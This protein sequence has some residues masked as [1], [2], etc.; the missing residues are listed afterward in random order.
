[1]AKELIMAIRTEKRRANAQAL[2][3]ALTSS[4]CA[5]KMRL[6]LHEAGTVCSEEGLILLQ[7]VNQPEELAALKAALDKIEGLHYQT[8]EV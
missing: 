5:I 6:G 2:Q 3:E 4:G 7:L 1:M 8:M